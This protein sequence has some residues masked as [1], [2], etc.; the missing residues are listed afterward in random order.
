[1]DNAF[2]WDDSFITGF[3]HVD[4]QHHVL[5]DLFNEL[6]QA[7]LAPS[8]DS[9]G[10][11]ADVYGRLLAYTEYHFREEEELMAQY[12]VDT[13]HVENHRNMHQQFI[14]QVQ[15]LWAQRSAMG[16][17]SAT[18]VGFLT[19][20]LGLHILGIDQSM[21]RQIAAIHEGIS[22]AD[23]YE[24][25]TK[26]HDNGTQANGTQANGTQALLRLIGKLYTAVST[27]NMQ[28]AQANQTLEDR[29]V[30]RTQELEAAMA[31][32]RAM[33]RT[34]GLL[35]IANRAHFHERLEQVCALALRG[36]RPVGVLMVDVDCFKAFNDHYGHLHGDACLQKIAKALTG[37][38]TAPRIWWPA[39]VAKSWW[40]CCPI[41]IWRGPSRWPSA[42]WRP[43]PSW[44]LPTRPRQQHRW[45]PSAWACAH[46]FPMPAQTT[47][48]ALPP[49]WPVPMRRCT[50]QK[51]RGA[52]A[53]WRD[54]AVAG[55]SPNA[56]RPVQ[57]AGGAFAFLFQ[58][59]AGRGFL[60]CG[61][62]PDVVQVGEGPVVGVFALQN[63]QMG[64]AA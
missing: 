11:L 49:C 30:Q 57:Q 2:I 50:V 19:S 45:S 29:V 22:P 6:N 9:D 40:C 20:W 42:W 41:P 48:A 35:G 61:G 58:D 3:D 52:I 1:M 16:D 39:M 15:V 59:G 28:L 38:R 5:V 36:E 24:F 54:S 23:A 32:L 33:A 63:P 31:R 14:D 13:R 44:A 4:Q 7:V 64:D 8:G 10:L 46:K 47:P 12:A 18:L 55:E 27:Q 26:F 34:D 51:I 60:R 56:K 17:P 43:W 21:A 37:C 62:L 53:G 25:E